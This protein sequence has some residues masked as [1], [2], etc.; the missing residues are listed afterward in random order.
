MYPSPS[1]RTVRAWQCIVLDARR[2]PVRSNCDDIASL[3]KVVRP[4]SCPTTLMLTH[5]HQPRLVRCHELRTLCLNDSVFSAL[6]CHA[7]FVV[8][9]RRFFPPPLIR[10]PHK[11]H[12]RP[13]EQQ[14]KSTSAPMQHGTPW[15]QREQ[16]RA[17]EEPECKPQR[18]YAIFP[19]ERLAQT[20]EAT[21]L[22]FHTSENPMWE[23]AIGVI[24]AHCSGD[25]PGK[26]SELAAGSCLASAGSAPGTAQ[27]AYR[28][29]QAVCARGI[30]VLHP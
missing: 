4:F 8:H 30:P 26:R 21:G 9:H 28:A 12:V 29:A 23:W 15:N 17:C 22:S 19:R 25:V 10:L 5:R 7:V 1:R 20:H 14:T 18:E 13:K 2:G 16:Q 3:T 6:V 11:V 24:E 27:A